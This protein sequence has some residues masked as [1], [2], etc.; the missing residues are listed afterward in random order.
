MPEERDDKREVF[1]R[2]LRKYGKPIIYI[3]GDR[4]DSFDYC[5]ENGIPCLFA[6][7]ENQPEIEQVNSVHNLRELKQELEKLQ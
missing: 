7:L 5:R 1:D 6:N 4:K 3:G 2:F